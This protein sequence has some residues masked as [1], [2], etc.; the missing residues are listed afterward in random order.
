MISTS[1]AIAN[2]VIAVSLLGERS[3]WLRPSR[4]TESWQ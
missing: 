3:W 1:A 2:V 4:A